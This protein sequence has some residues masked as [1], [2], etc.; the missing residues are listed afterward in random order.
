MQLIKYT[1]P[2]QTTAATHGKS[3]VTVTPFSTATGYSYIILSCHAALVFY[4][5]S[6][7]VAL[8]IVQGWPI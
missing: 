2:L 3:M 8:Y 7:K 4:V 1:K 6:Y 5:T